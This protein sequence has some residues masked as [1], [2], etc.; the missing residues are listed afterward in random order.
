MR[1]VAVA[2]TSAACL[3][4]RHGVAH[5]APHPSAES[6]YGLHRAVQ[7]VGG[8]HSNP[9]D[10]LLPEGAAFREAALHPPGCFNA[11]TQITPPRGTSVRV[12]RNRSM[13]SCSRWALAPHPDC[14]A[15]YWRPS[16]ANDVGYTDDAGVGADSPELLAGLGVE[17]AEEPV[18]GPAHEDEA[19]GGGENRSHD[20]G[21]ERPAPDP[22]AGIEVPRLELADMAG[23]VAYQHLEPGTHELLSR[24]VLHLV[25]PSSTCT[26]SRWQECRGAAVDRVEGR[27][28]PV[29]A[30]LVGRAEDRAPAGSRNAR[31]GRT[32][33]GPCAHR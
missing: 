24:R 31:P 32:T 28:L 19:A 20:V 12:P 29:L 30:P 27:R 11:N 2:T 3:V 17:G 1:P 16:T 6:P 18:A 33:A 23:A 9:A 26:G 21:L 5:E 15:M 25:A 13:W 8:I 22:L 4:H 10:R 14:T 7:A